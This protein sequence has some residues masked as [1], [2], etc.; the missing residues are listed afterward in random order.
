MKTENG[1]G[2]AAEVTA[3]IAAKVA[4][5]PETPA[6]VVRVK[7]TDVIL[8]LIAEASYLTLDQRANLAAD[9]DKVINKV[10]NARPS[11]KSEIRELIFNAP[12]E[13]ISRDGIMKEWNLR[14]ATDN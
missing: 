5:T 7:V 9:I 11:L 4:A 1:I 2:T 14:G 13:G 10:T 3:E 8:K 12:A 6:K